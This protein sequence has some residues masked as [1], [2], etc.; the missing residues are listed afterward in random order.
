[1]ADKLFPIGDGS[2]FKRFKDMG[3]GTHAE[4]VSI[5]GSPEIGAP[6]SD[7]LASKAFP[8]LNNVTRK[9][10]NVTTFPAF[11]TTPTA[12]GRS[13]RW[14]CERERRDRDDSEHAF[15]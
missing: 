7:V 12:A 3:D 8:Y 6:G 14:R 5:F 10:L 1:M 13:C 4:V 2:S 9:A 11:T 15:A